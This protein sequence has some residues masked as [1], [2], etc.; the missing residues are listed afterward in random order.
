MRY[1]LYLQY[2]DQKFWLAPK[3]SITVEEPAD[4]ETVDFG[5]GCCGDVIDRTWHF[6][7]RFLGN[8]SLASAWALYNA[9]LT[10]LENACA[11]NT[12]LL[13]NRVV[14]D[15]PVLTFRVTKPQAKMLDP[16]TQYIRE[17]ILSIDLVLTLN[18]WTVPDGVVLLV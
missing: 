9:L 1:Q 2:D 15:E 4:M 3:S 18:E 17:R 10:F 6:K 12:D 8:C 11:S 13:L 16:N 5:G 14:W 7:L